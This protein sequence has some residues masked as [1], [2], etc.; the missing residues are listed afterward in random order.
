[1]KPTFFDVVIAFGPFCHLTEE[2]ERQAAVR[3]IYRVLKPGGMAMAAFI[4]YLSGSIAIVARYL[5]APYQVNRDN[6]TEVFHSGRFNNLTDRGFQEGYY[7]ESEERTQLF[8]ANGFDQ[9]LMR[10][11]RGF[12]YEKEEALY[13]IQ[14]QEMKEKIFSLICQ[15]ATRKEIIETCGHA[16][17]IGTKM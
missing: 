16:V 7:T 13:A 8:R 17:Y 4:P 12:A 14:D 9:L 2:T 1:M 3:E 6:Q 10:S 11:I 5:F 15:T